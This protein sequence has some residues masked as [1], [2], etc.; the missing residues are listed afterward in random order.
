[1]VGSSLQAGAGGGGRWMQLKR[2]AA[3]A[4]AFP[5]EL[6]C[7]CILSLVPKATI[8][9]NERTVVAYMLA[10][11]Y[12]RLAGK[13]IQ[14]T[15]REPKITFKSHISCLQ[16]FQIYQVA[17]DGRFSTDI[18]VLQPLGSTT[19]PPRRLQAFMCVGHYWAQAALATCVR[20]IYESF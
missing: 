16:Q 5:R 10:S 14:E 18:G 9:W 1:M 8:V 7:T 20:S 17:E 12:L 3:E 13:C 15:F 4:A 19:G 11:R 2:A 6:C